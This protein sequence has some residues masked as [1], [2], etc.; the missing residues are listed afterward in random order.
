MQAG[1]DGAMVLIRPER[2]DDVD[3]V[4]ALISAAFRIDHDGPVPEAVLNDRLRTS[5]AR[6]GDLTL[7]AE[8]DGTVVGQLTC[9]DGVVHALEDP[10]RQTVAPAIGPVAV[11]PD[12][13][14]S[15]VGS[16]LL[17]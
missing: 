5:S 1:G 13:G 6:R 12:F 11:L 14:R 17:E 9:S 16:S 10:A 8:L 4:R 2:L 15:G 7:V 3:A